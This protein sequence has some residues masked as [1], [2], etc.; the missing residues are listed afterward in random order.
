VHFEFEEG[1]RKPA[2][3]RFQGLEKRLF[4]EL[5]LAIEQKSDSLW[6]YRGKIRGIFY[7]PFSTFTG[8]NSRASQ[9]TTNT[10]KQC[11]TP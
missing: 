6:E 11:G 7:H 9:R 5:R 1:G 3:L 2:F 10:G 4:T 8:V